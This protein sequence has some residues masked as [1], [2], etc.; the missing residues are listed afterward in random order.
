MKNVSATL[1][2]A[3]LAVFCGS[4]NAQVTVSSFEKTL[5]NPEVENSTVQTLDTADLTRKLEAAGWHVL[6]EENG[7][8]I[9]TRNSRVRNSVTS[10]TNPWQD[11]ERQ[12]QETGWTTRRDADGSLVLIPPA[13]PTTAAPVVQTGQTGSF[14][15]MQQK[16]REA[17]WEV[18]NTA[19]GSI[20]L[21]PPSSKV[22]NKPRA[23][24]GTPQTAHVTLPVDS[25]QKAH[26]IATNWL[27]HQS[28]FNATVGKIRKILN[29]YIISIVADRTPHTL[30]Q[31]IAIRNTDG[32]VIVLN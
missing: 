7:N 29:V 19:D 1:L 18:T 27:N 20:L 24:P 31:Q 28:G 21:Y 17:G 11:I 30:I 9:V 8:L 23:C 10:G 26:S 6:Q 3:T 16:L 5:E 13:K 32:A 12:L 25:W 15:D 4:I 2:A 14:E 22:T